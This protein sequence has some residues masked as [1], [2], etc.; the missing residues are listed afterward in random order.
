MKKTFLLTRHKF[1]PKTSK[2][3]FGICGTINLVNGIRN[4]SQD[5]LT[6]WELIFGVLTV[7]CGL[8]II[9]L[10]FVLFNP[11]HKLSPK[12]AIDEDLILIRENIFKKTKQIHW[13][14]LSQI[15]FRSF[16]LDFIYK[17]NTIEPL[18]LK[19]SAE[20]SLEIKRSLREIA[21]KKSVNITGG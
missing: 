5:Y 16:A 18:Q 8:L 17:N 12:I 20:R 13:N 4:L 14:D 11:D 3:L 2:S 1:A 9:I 7:L 10:G 21:D 6:N 19:T 15:S